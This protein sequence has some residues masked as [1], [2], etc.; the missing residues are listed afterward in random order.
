MSAIGDLRAE[1]NKATAAIISIQSACSHPKEC[2]TKVAGGDTGNYCKSD[3][4]Y[5]YDFKCGL[6]EKRWTED[7]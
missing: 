4:S 3:D 2:V 5:W 7:Q 6:C 1:I